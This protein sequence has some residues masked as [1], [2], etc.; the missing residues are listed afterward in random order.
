MGSDLWVEAKTAA[1][2]MSEQEEERERSLFSM[3]NR[4]FSTASGHSCTNVV[5]MSSMRGSKSKASNGRTIKHSGS[6]LPQQMVSKHLL[7]KSPLERIVKSRVFDFAGAFIIIAFLVLLGIETDYIAKNQG[8]SS[9]EFFT[10]TV[11]FNIW[12]MVEL[13]LRIIVERKDFFKAEQ[14]TLNIMDMAFVLASIVDMVMEVMSG[15]AAWME[16]SMIIGRALRSV[17][18]LRVMRI[19]RLARVLRHVQQ[20]QKMVCLIQSSTSTLLWCL[21]LLLCLLFMFAVFFTQGFADHIAML[22]TEEHN[23]VQSMLKAHYGSMP[24]TLSTLFQSMSGGVDWGQ[25]V[26]PLQRLNPVY[27]VLF[28]AFINFSIFG[29]LNVMT[30]VFV[31][32]TMKSALAYRDFIVMDA[33]KN[34]ETAVQH[35]KKVFQE[36]DVDKDGVLTKDEV[37]CFLQDERVQSYIEALQIDLS[38]ADT[39]FSL[40]DSSRCGHISIDDFCDG[41]LKLRGDAKAFDV[42]CMIYDISRFMEKWSDFT[43]YTVKQFQKMD[44]FCK[45]VRRDTITDAPKPNS[46]AHNGLP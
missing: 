45:D 11:A 46:S 35:L 4:K 43:E 12:F 16:K 24:R 19:M 42:H 10:T 33:Q 20:F 29:V 9:P 1:P 34:K 31:E 27:V 21:V 30:S 2:T 40:L 17:R 26:E 18:I 7:K 22:N 39:L 13:F 25:V 36:M 32:T 5:M 14:R 6:I 15:K 28:F 38:D 44:H 41:C 23:A 3:K 8:V 37:V